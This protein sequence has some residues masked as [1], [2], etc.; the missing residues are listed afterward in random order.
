M[1]TLEV[2]ALLAFRQSIKTDLTGALANWTLERNF[3]HCRTWK[4]V[5]CGKFGQVTGINLADLGLTG[6]IATKIGDLIHLSFLNLSGNNL[7]GP[8]PSDLMKCQNHSCIIPAPLGELRQLQ[9]L[10]LKDNKL[11]GSIAPSLGKCS[12]LTDLLLGST[13]TQDTTA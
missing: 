13:V 12:S 2:N 9:L 10:Y 4:D 6:T 1:R 8:I 11:T 5:I 7:F 3:S